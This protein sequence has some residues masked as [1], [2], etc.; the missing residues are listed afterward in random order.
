MQSDETIS[1][2]MRQSIL[3]GRFFFL[4]LPY[5][6]IQISDENLVRYFSVHT[7]RLELRVTSGIYDLRESQ[8]PHGY[9]SAPIGLVPSTVLL[10]L[11]RRDTY[12]RSS[13]RADS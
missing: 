1:A 9:Q 11:S 2:V 12:H 8:L 13:R 4:F 3:L 10:P 5:Y 6:N 7:N